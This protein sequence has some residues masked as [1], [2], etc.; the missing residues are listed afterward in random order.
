MNAV[1]EMTETMA[2]NEMRAA[3]GIP[4]KISVAGL[5]A[6]VRGEARAI[7]AQ[8]EPA[9]GEEQPFE[10]F[11]GAVRKLWPQTSPPPTHGEVSFLADLCGKAGLN[12][13]RS[14]CQPEQIGRFLYAFMRMVNFAGSFPRIT[15]VDLDTL[16]YS[17][18]LDLLGTGK[19]G[20][21]AAMLGRGGS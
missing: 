1:R 3:F 10:Q 8:A 15:M 9:P 6:V 5:W 2:V 4:A 7:C 21:K 17:L 16:E 19:S 11:L 14:D 20:M 12:G 18:H 13:S